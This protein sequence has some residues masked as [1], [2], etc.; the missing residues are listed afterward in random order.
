MHP[1]IL[2]TATALTAAAHPTANPSKI[3]Q[4][5]TIPLT[6]T[7]NNLAFGLPKFQN[8]FDVADFVDTITSRNALTAASVI[9]PNRQT[10]TANYS[11]SATFC[12]P[13]IPPKNHKHTV[14]IATHGLNF[15]RSYWDPA[16][17]KPTYSFV[18]WA[19]GN[20]YSILYYDR[21][22]VGKSS[23][24]SGYVA[25]LANQVAVATELTK[26]VKQGE[27]VAGLGKPDAVVL[28]GH[29][30]G[31]HVS[32]ATV[33]ESPDLVDGV[34][35]TGFS[36]NATWLNLNGFIGAV[37]L[38]VASGQDAGK[39]GGLDTGYLTPVDLYAN[40]GSFFK[41]PDYSHEVAM[42]ADAVKT[43]F[44]VTELLDDDN[45]PSPPFAFKGAAM[46]ISGKYDFIFCT[47]D[48]DDV[49]ENPGRQAFANA[50]AFKAV[51]YPGAGHGL[52]LHLNAAGSFKEITDFL[53][54]NG[55]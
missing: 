12:K 37:G 34:V 53:G 45:V 16:L 52:N 2:L 55:L 46:I 32:L 1:A 31:S 25:Q 19:V 35:L 22:G 6:I 50:R 47:S 42:Y 9:A 18:D 28:V 36:L 21:L 15:D 10:L 44:A 39:W 30:F 26:L 20:G 17:P 40:V 23:Q 54:E 27:Y 13:A 33:A 38:R 3:C 4:D 5:Y 48:C 8:N 7:S 29:S 14:L 41:A 51:S 11:I 49:L 43:P 24:V